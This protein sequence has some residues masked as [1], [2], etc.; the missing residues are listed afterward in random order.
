MGLY[1]LGL[2]S[3]EQKSPLKQYSLLLPKV[4]FTDT[5][6]TTTDS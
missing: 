1:M 3:A 4:I 2:T 5:R 6:E